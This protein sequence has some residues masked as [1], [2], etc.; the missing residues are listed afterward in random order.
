M[1]VL[2]SCKAREGDRAYG[3]FPCDVRAPFGKGRVKVHATFAGVPY[4]GSLARMGTPAHIL[5]LRKDIRRAI[6]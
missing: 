6:G 5:G 2:P 4:A 3:V 1:P